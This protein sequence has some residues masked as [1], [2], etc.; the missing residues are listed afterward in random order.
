ML[1]FIAIV[2]VAIWGIAMLASYTIGGYVHTVILGAVV[3]L[4]VR[5]IRE[6]ESRH[7]RVPLRRSH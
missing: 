5:I 4:L 7:P 6:P 2:L 1:P 3:L